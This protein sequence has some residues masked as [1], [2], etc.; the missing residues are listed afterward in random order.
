MNAYY[1]DLWSAARR[2]SVDLVALVRTICVVA[3]RKF[4]PAWRLLPDGLTT[5]SLASTFSRPKAANS[6]FLRE[7]GP[8]GSGL[9]G[10]K[11]EGKKN[12]F[13]V[14]SNW[15]EFFVCL[16]VYFVCWMS[17]FVLFLY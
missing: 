15:I 8:W 4:F 2:D 3:L 7:R 11:N 12:T 6:Y 10:L 16:F 5:S 9:P 1:V 13:G 14:L 17:F